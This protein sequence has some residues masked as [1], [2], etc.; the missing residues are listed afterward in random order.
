MMEEYG[1]DIKYIKLP[2]ID[3]VY[4]LIW[5]LFI[6]SEAKESDITRE[7]LSERYCVNELDSETFPLKHP[8]IDKY[9]RND[10]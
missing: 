3:A 4:S 9:Q 1:P 8:T 6:N 2:D 10:K 5:I 7:I